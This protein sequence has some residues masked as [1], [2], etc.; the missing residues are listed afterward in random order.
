MRV[1]RSI[2]IPIVIIIIIIAFNNISG[3]DPGERSLA[4]TCD[5]WV[6]CSFHDP[7]VAYSSTRLTQFGIAVHRVRVCHTLRVVDELSHSG[8]ESVCVFDQL[9][10]RCSGWRLQKAGQPGPHSGSD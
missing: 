10:G 4:V 3:F 7:F 9:V 8:W 1:R 5:R 2:T 6:C